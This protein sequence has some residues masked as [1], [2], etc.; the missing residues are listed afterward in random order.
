MSSTRLADTDRL[1]VRSV[2][3]PACGS[4][5]PFVV[6]LGLYQHCTGGI[7]YKKTK[8]LLTSQQQKSP[9][10]ISHHV[11]ALKKILPVFI[12]QR[13]TAVFA[14]KRCMGGGVCIFAVLQSHLASPPLSLRY[15]VCASGRR[16]FEDDVC[17]WANGNWSSHFLSLSS[18]VSQKSILF[19]P[20]RTFF[21]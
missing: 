12:H 9:G 5:R 15:W 19:R 2:F 20:L 17:A 4:P 10:T 18:L 11:M 6:V 14:Q 8:C 3:S 7:Q 16:A 13:N 1:K 21:A